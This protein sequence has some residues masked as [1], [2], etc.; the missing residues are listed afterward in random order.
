MDKEYTA[1]DVLEVLRN[2]AVGDEF[3]E[4][5]TT[6]MFV[7]KVDSDFVWLLT[8]QGPGTLPEIGVVEKITRQQYFK[9]MCYD[10]MEKC[11][12]C[13]EGRH[14]VK[15]WFEEYEQVGKVKDRTILSLP[16]FH[17]AGI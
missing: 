11:M 15:G 1:K 16:K 14:N 8:V 12:Y 3:H 9:Q 10:T 6:W 17:G 4:M 7:V 13:Y 2:P 5:C